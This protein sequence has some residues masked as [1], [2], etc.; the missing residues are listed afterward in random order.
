VIFSCCARRK[1]SEAVDEFVT[2]EEFEADKP[3][4]G[5]LRSVDW[6]C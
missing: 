1:R 6:I 3:D 2:A 4:V 5:V